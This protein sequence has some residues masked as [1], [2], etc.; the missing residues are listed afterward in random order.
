MRLAPVSSTTVRIISQQ[1]VAEED[2]KQAD[3]MG[4]SYSWH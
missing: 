2:L 3:K 1:K 4:L